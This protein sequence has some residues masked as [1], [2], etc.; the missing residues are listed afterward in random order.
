MLHPDDPDLFNWRQLASMTDQVQVLRSHVVTKD[1]SRIPVDVHA[2]RLINGQTEIIQWIHKDITDQVELEAMREDLMAMLFHDLQSPLSNV[3]SGLEL[4][5]YELDPVADDKAMTILSIARRSSQRLGHLIRSLLDISRLE[6]GHTI[7]NKRPTTVERMV[8]LAMEV[9]EPSMARRNVAFMRDVTAAL[10]AVVVDQD[11]ITRVLINLLD[12]ALKYSDGGQNITVSAHALPATNR[13]R[14]AVADEGPGI[15]ESQRSAIF[16][17][18]YRLH[19]EGTAKG[20]GLGLAF[21]RMAVEG[22]GG[23]IWVEEAPGGGAMFAFTLP[24]GAQEAHD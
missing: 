22:H 11:M 20:L 21:C 4:L 7:T 19:G 6:A 12:N 5:E 16:D 13:V 9:V 8:D 14:L 1:M 15:P 3:I 10:P 23:R 18:F 17:K 24:A 2:K